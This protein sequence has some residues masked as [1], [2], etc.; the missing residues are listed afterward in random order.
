M[1][2][3]LAILFAALL[4][5]SFAGC[6]DDKKDNNANKNTGSGSSSST[7]DKSTVDSENKEPA[8]IIESTTEDV[9]DA[10]E[11]PVADGTVEEWLAA[12]KDKVDE[13]YTSSKISASAYGNELYLTVI[14]EG[15]TDEEI[16]EIKA[17][18][19]GL[20]ES[21]EAKTSEEKVEEMKFYAT[22]FGEDSD[23]PLPESATE[24]IMDEAGNV[25]YEITYNLD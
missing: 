21:W 20:E 19:E 24:I 16:E 22:L 2:K 4:I 15:Y 12:N 3:V 11:T 23:M 1:K 14:A 18:F 17:S 25:I 9:T 7:T 5:F 13:L 8:G 10:P 6:G